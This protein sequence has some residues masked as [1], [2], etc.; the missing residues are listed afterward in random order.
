MKS[1]VCRC[2]REAH[3]KLP[4]EGLGPKPYL[5]D[6]GI[7]GVGVRLVLQAGGMN[8]IPGGGQTDACKQ[9]VAASVTQEGQRN[10]DA[11]RTLVNCGVFRSRI[12]WLCGHSF[13]TGI[14]QGVPERGGGEGADVTGML[15]SATTHT[16]A[17]DC[18]KLSIPL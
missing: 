6:W 8:G 3:V 4:R 2:C 9:C 16:A 5:Q 13:G 18:L 11:Q 14:S 1:C 7:G 10:C 15:K 12:L 17:N